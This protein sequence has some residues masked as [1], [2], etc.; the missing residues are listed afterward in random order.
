M[1]RAASLALHVPEKSVCDD[2]MQV[3]MKSVRIL[4]KSVDGKNHTGNPVL[5]TDHFPQKC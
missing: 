5:Q 3:G 4:A 1:F 2:G